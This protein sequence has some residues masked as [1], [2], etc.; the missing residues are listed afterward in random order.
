M[1]ITEFL[2]RV[3]VHF[4]SASNLMECV[5]EL[6]QATQISERTKLAGPSGPEERVRFALDPNYT[7]ETH[8]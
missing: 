6:P 4:P 8:P 7:A 2:K 1:C 3:S 5:N